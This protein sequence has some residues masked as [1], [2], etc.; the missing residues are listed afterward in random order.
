MNSYFHRQGSAHRSGLADLGWALWCHA[1]LQVLGS[2]LFLWQVSSFSDLYKGYQQPGADHRN[3][4][5]DFAWVMYIKI[6]MAKAGHVVKSMST[7]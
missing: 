2:T 6:P 4:S 5:E 3:T 7:G 1:Q